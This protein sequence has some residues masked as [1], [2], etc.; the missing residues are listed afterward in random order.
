M[1]AIKP[2]GNKR[3]KENK[4]KNWRRKREKK[5]QRM[6][7]KSKHLLAAMSRWQ[8]FPGMKDKG[9]TETTNSKITTTLIEMLAALFQELVSQTS[10]TTA[11]ITTRERINDSFSKITT[12]TKTHSILIIDEMTNRFLVNNA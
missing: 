10:R 11:L 12:M 7:F 3:S 1:K 6:L 4:R 9:Q 5:K 2:K 8:T